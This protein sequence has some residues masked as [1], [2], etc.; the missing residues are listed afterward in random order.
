[1]DEMDEQ[2]ITNADGTGFDHANQC[3]SQTT[4]DDNDPTDDNGGSDDGPIVNEHQCCGTYPN[5]F[6]FMDKGGERACC[7]EVTYNTNKLECCNGGF[8]GAIGSCTSA[9]RR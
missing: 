1:M 2:F 8:L 4:E 9:R 5:R 7:G 6:G 3:R